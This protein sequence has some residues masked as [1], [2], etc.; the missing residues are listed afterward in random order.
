MK[1]TLFH[2][3]V[4]VAKKG[5]ASWDGHGFIERRHFKGW[6]MFHR[7]GTVSQQ[8]HFFIEKGMVSQRRALFH[9]KGMIA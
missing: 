5:I 3:T 8:G 2:R 4:I 6:A 9:R 1:K 7:K